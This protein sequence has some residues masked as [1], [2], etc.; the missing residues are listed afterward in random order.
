MRK[1]VYNT[2]RSNNPIKK[3]INS[4][5]ANSFADVNNGRNFFIILESEKCLTLNSLR[6]KSVDRI[7]IP[8][9]TT[10]FKTIKRACKNTYNMW[11]GDY[12][13][14][15]KSDMKGR[16]GGVWLDYCCS[17]KGN[18]HMNPIEDI[19]KLFN[20]R[21]LAKNSRL[22]F[23]FCYRK[24]G[25][26]SKILHED[27]YQIEAAIQAVAY[28]NGYAL[29]RIPYGRMYNGMFFGLFEVHKFD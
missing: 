10:A 4:V 12:L 13:D 2:Q 1:E 18:E 15:I 28:K 14:L 26:K 23:T 11:L 17:V 3:D 16:V 8:N 20:Y 29:I 24:G 5:V 7:E 27:L 22:A 19:N 21:L 9:P 6:K 25:E